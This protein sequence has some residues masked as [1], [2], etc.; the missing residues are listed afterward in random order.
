MQP[1]EDVEPGRDRVEDDGPP[2]RRQLAAGRG[3]PDQQRV[4]R[5]GERQGLG[6]ARDDRDVVAGQELVHVPAG[7][8]GIEDRDDVVGPVADDP[9]RGLGRVLAEGPFGQD[10]EAASFGRAHRASVGNRGRL[11][12]LPGRPLTAPCRAVA[13]GPVE[14][15]MAGHAHW[16]GDAGRGGP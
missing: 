2:G 3:D 16:E 14:V 5:L 12:R 7:L 11:R 8:G 13:C 10:Q 9:V 4:R 6:Q 1:T 15:S